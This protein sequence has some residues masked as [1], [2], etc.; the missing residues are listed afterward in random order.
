MPQYLSADEVA[1]KFGV[2]TTKLDRIL[3]RKDCPENMTDDE[4]N[5]DVEKVGEFLSHMKKLAGY[6]RK[7]QQRKREEQKNTPQRKVPKSRGAK[8]GPKGPRKKSTPVAI[9]SANSRKFADFHAFKRKFWETNHR[10]ERYVD[11]D[12]TSAELN[13]FILAALVFGWQVHTGQ[14]MEAYS[15]LGIPGNISEPALSAIW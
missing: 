2:S 5:F 9:A 11:G 1:A 8:R 15:N 3:D 6:S 12:L 13:Q 10:W 14:N 4:G 7:S